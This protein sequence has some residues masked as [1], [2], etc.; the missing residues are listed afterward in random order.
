MQGQSSAFARS[1]S[2][3]RSVDVVLFHSLGLLRLVHRAIDAGANFISESF[4]FAFAAAISEPS[5]R[6]LG[7]PKPPPNLTTETFARSTVMGES[8]RSRRAE[9]KRRDAVHDQLETY[10]V[11]IA[12]LKEALAEERSEREAGVSR[13]RDLE[14]IVEEVRSMSSSF[15]SLPLSPACG[16]L[17]SPRADLSR[18]SQIV[19]IGLRGGFIDVSPQWESHVRI[20]QQARAFGTSDR[21]VTDEPDHEELETAPRS[22]IVEELKRSKESSSVES[23]EES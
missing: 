2:P 10:G 12:D 1:L 8:W 11:E 16:L 19:A 22:I 20:G 9:G 14:K 23:N 18:H 17:P 7:F 21:A 3:S 4:L 6:L 5:F 15:A 13:E